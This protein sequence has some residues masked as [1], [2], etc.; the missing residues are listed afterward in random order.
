MFE[1][2]NAQSAVVIGGGRGIGLG[3]VYQLLHDYP[4]LELFATYRSAD[5]A[6][7]LLELEA[8]HASR[9]STVKCDPLSEQELAELASTIKEQHKNIDLILIAPGILHLP[10]G[11]PEKSL[12]NIDLTQLQEV[13]QV[14]A[15]ITPL[16]AK[17]MKKLISRSQPSAFI[18]LSAMVGSI[19]D[20][21]LGGWYGYRASKTALNMFLKTIA[22]EL[23]RSGF[24][25]HVGA[26]HPGTTKTDLSAK[27]VDTVQHK[28]WD[29]QGSAK[30]ILQVINDLN[31]GETGFFK[32]WDG[33]TIPW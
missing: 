16:V 22:I 29:P 28:V 10:G 23:Q 20:N 8:Q 7:G 17:H 14:N 32:N 19:E 1:I 25:A 5:R 4:N 24:K 9:L 26:I 18:S 31:P 12:R 30:N 33:T 11:S 2:Q 6:L 15:F 27:F 21:E 13:F 3:L